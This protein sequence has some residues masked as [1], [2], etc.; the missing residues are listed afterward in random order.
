MPFWQ[1]LGQWLQPTIQ[2]QDQ[3]FSLGNRGEQPGAEEN[4]TDL[5]ADARNRTQGMLHRLDS[6]L[7]AV[8]DGADAVKKAGDLSCSLDDNLRRIKSL[9]RMPDNKDLVER[10]LQ[11]AT[12]P[13]T[14]AVLLFME[15]LADKVTIN[16]S[17]LEPLMLIAHLDHHVG[18]EGEH[19][20]SSFSVE[21]VLKRL[22]PGHQVS[23]KHDLASIADSLLSGDSV[24]LCEG[25]R[26]ALAIETKGFPMRS[27]AESKNEQVVWGPHDTF[28]EAF[29]VNVALVRRRLKDPR[30]VTEILTVG[31]LSHNYVAMMY[32]DSIAS[33]KLVAE[34]KRRVEA[35]KVDVVNTAGTLEQFIEDNPRS[36]LPGTLI[37]E[38][39]DR[40]AAY[41]AEGHVALLV[42]NSPFALICPVTFWSL[43][44]TAEDYYLRY[45]FGTFLRFIRLT[46]LL[47]ALTLPA[48]YIAIINYHHEML[49][50][51]LMLFIAA[52]REVVP[53]PAV[54]ELLLMDAVFELIREAGTR[55]PGV[56]G[57][58]IGLVASLI[59]GQAAVEAKIVSPLMIL[60]V[61]IT[62]LSS[63]AIPNYSVGFGVRLLRF[64]LLALATV[65]GFYGVALGL[66][67]LV[68]MLS[69]E[70]SFGVPYLAPLAP[71]RGGLTDIFNR[72][73]LYQMEM[74]PSFLRPPNQRRQKEVV[75]A[76]DPTAPQPAPSKEGKSP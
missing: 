44:Q 58:T 55:I 37:T 59:L 51:E 25:S 18:Q 13:P 52:S 27:V 41:L 40:T 64:A 75:R 76:W 53:M 66:F 67:V 29:R 19:G 54:V 60:V 48:L 47:I 46:A 22:L 2:T 70:R 4:E 57:P 17:I 26:T 74:R 34:V 72:Q 32:I 50:T 45:P 28:I 6:L 9:F 3:S 73:P 56:I 8:P 21:M 69:A 11:I 62:G 23:E 20:P 10:K 12:Q 63:F 39:P 16:Q 14:R 35:L 71:T 68:V 1:R 33:P 7:S 42:D 31:D 15:G 36:L 65:L 38:R 24:L 5:L 49:P 43:L 61:A 30:V